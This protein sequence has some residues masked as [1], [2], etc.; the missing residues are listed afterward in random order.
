MVWG[1]G[2]VFEGQWRNDERHYGRMI[3]ANNFVY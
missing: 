3:M 1:D 2:S